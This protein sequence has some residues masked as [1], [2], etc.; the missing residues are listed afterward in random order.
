MEVQY[1]RFNK[2]KGSSLSVLRYAISELEINKTNFIKFSDI[3]F[4]LNS[5]HDKYWTPQ[6]IEQYFINNIPNET[7]LKTRIIECAFCKNS[8]YAFISQDLITSCVK[9]Y[10]GKK[11][12]TY[13]RIKNKCS[14]RFIRNI[15]KKYLYSELS[16][17]LYMMQRRHDKV[18]KLNKNRKYLTKIQWSSEWK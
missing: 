9:L 2:D 13:G 18:R 11:C 4:F 5:L 7:S 17:F 8:F 12:S 3:K 16:S 15:P 1:L 14:G 6:H 10:C